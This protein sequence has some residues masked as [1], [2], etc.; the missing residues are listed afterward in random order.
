MKRRTIL[1]GVSS[2]FPVLAG[3]Q[4][5]DN[6]DNN[7]STTKQSPAG[8]QLVV[9]S[10]YPVEGTMVNVGASGA[11]VNTASIELVNCIIEV[12]GDVGGDTYH[13]QA[14]RDQ[15]GI[16]ESWEWEVAFGSE[17]D[18]KQDNSVENLS[19]ETHAEYKS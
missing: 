13:G 16:S 6:A 14:T 10:S 15:L 19:I 12:S 3:C 4:A 7:R 11:A 1:G 8:E 9:E 5:L 17:A 18:A 2:L